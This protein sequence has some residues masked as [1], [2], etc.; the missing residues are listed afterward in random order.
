MTTTDRPQAVRHRIFLYLG[1]LV[2]LL[3]FGSPSVGLI[4]IPIS[5]LLKNK[6]N[7][8]A[9][10]LA[11]FRLV[12]AIPLYLSFV[13]GF[14]RDTWSPL[15]LGDRGFMLLFGAAIMVTLT[16]YAIWRPAFVFD[17]IRPEQAP[18]I[19]PL[20]DIRRLLRHCPVYP[21]LLIWLL[22]SFAPGSQTPPQYYL[23][24]T[25]HADDAQ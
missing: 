2:F 16:G 1:G 22:W 19:H 11:I 13:F 18:V 3:A 17:N 12:V 25:L 6:L 9:N 10:E 5:F 14:I 8:T 23:Q 21:A 24:N 7:L 20:A 4:D 15:G